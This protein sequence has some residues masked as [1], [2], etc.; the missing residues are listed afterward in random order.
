ML[1]VASVATH[2][3]SAHRP[4]DYVKFSGA[5]DGGLGVPSSA[6]TVN[7]VRPWSHDIDANLLF[8]IICERLKRYLAQLIA[9]ARRCAIDDVAN[10]PAMA[11]SIM[12]AALTQDCSRQ[13]RSFMTGAANFVRK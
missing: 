4:G 1:R 7:M 10:A 3:A 2:R 13:G 11:T 12:P 5:L 9:S 8:A 6:F